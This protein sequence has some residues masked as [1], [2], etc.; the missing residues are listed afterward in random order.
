MTVSSASSLGT[1]GL[2]SL[3]RLSLILSR[4]P[5]A[6]PCVYPQGHRCLSW[7]PTP[8]PTHTHASSP[9]RP[10]LRGLD[11]PV[12]FLLALPCAGDTPAGVGVEGDPVSPPWQ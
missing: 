6:P 8:A 4:S 7:T 2:V 5:T 1:H 12:S 10:P 3:S 11:L 9:R